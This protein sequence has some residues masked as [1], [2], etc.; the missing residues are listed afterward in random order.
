MNAQELLEAA[1]DAIPSS[2][3]TA[4]GRIALLNGS[5]KSRFG[6]CCE[7]LLGQ[8]VEVLVPEDLRGPHE[9]YRS[10]YV[11]SPPARWGSGWS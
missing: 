4:E 6:Y 7:E 5:Q 8:P 10:S 11:D 3:P 2:R 9:K 1:P